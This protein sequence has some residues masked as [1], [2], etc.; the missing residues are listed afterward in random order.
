MQTAKQHIYIWN[1]GVAA[2]ETISVTVKE[3]TFPWLQRRSHWSKIKFTASR[4]QTRHD[5]EIIMGGRDAPK[6]E[7]H[8]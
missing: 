6:Q 8:L 5:T 4:Q 7:I 1:T 3:A 2:A